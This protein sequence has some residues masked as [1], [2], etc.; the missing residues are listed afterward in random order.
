MMQYLILFAAIMVC[1]GLIASALSKSKTKQADNRTQESREDAPY[2]L[3][4]PLFTPAELAFLRVLDLAAGE[5]YRVFGKVRVADVIA[6]FPVRD[7]GAWQRAFNK[8]SA[9]HFDFVLCRRDTMAVVAAIE[10]NDSSHGRKKRQTRDAFLE[11]VCASVK[12]PLVQIRA[13]VDYPVESVRNQ[14]ADA[15]RMTE[16]SAAPWS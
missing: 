5:H 9:K 16:N 15:L 11:E 2:T 6:V 3:S 8:I 13:A 14:L 12:L 10:L 1:A 4:D 7:R